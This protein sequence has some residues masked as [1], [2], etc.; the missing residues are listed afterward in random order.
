MISA[1]NFLLTKN[2]ILLAVGL[3]AF[4]AASVGQSAKKFRIWSG[5]V[6]TKVIPANERYSNENFR[7]G[8]VLFGNEKTSSALLNYNLLY[9]DI[10]YID[11]EGDTLSIANEELV[12]NVL[13]GNDLYYFNYRFGYLEVLSDYPSLKLAAKKGMT[14]LQKD[15]DVYVNPRYDHFSKLAEDPF[16]NQDRFFNNTVTYRQMYNMPAKDDFYLLESTSY[17][18]IDKNSRSHPASL[19]SLRKIFPENKRTIK[20]YLKQNNVNF[21]NRDDLEKLVEFCNHLVL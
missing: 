19:K 9:S 8:I 2:L 13:I 6:A 21:K 7:K 11:Q 1:V 14:L 4:P 17:Y 12:R 15:K 20:K 3:F 10:E 16:T 18:F 5:E